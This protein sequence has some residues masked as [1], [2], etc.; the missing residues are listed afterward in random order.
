MAPF[1]GTGTGPE[2][3]ARNTTVSSASP[4]SPRDRPVPF[5]TIVVT[6]VTATK[7]CGKAVKMR[8]GPG[9]VGLDH[10]RIAEAVDD[11]AG[12][13]IGLGMD[14][15]VE[16]RIEQPL[17]QGQRRGKTAR[18]PALSICA[19][20]SR[21][22]IRAMIFDSVLTVTR[23]KGRALA[24]LQHRK[25]AGGERLR[26]PVGDQ[27]IG[28][29]PGKAMTDRARLGLGLQADDG[30][31]GGIERRSWPPLLRSDAA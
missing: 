18:E 4:S 3:C 13:A 12:Q 11:D 19:S 5:L 22:S 27:F 31:G 6:P 30:A 1:I 21:S 9:G 24:I 26:A 28:I 17:A 2:S 7:C 20:G 15:P 8:L 16:G 10:G 29:D 23:P 25:R 14:E